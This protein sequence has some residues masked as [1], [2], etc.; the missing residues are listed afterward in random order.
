M[1]GGRREMLLAAAALL[2]RSR[3]RCPGPVML[4]D[5]DARVGRGRRAET[6]GCGDAGGAGQLGGCRVVSVRRC[7]WIKPGGGPAVLVGPSQL[8][9]VG[10]WG[11]AGWL[12]VV[13]VVGA[14]RV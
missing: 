8:G 5:R 7:W 14:G 9:V 13:G 12:G 1:E 3:V 10:W 11:Q 6:S 4:V 2:G